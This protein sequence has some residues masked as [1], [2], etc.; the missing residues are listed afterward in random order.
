MPSIHTSLLTPM[1]VWVGQTLFGLCSGGVRRYIVTSPPENAV[2]AA[3][4]NLFGTIGSRSTVPVAI[5]AVE[6]SLRNGLRVAC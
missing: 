1:P 2:N 5:S 4:A 6:S 3:P